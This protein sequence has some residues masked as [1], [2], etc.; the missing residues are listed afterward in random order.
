MDVVVNSG[1]VCSQNELFGDEYLERLNE[2]LLN[3][4]L[5]VSTSIVNSRIVS[6]LPYNE[7]LVCNALYRNMVADE[8][9]LTATDLCGMTSMLKSQMN[10]TLNRLEEK[11]LIFRQRSTVDRRQVF[12]LFN[13]EKS[14]LY[15]SQHTRILKFLDTVIE[16]LGEDNAVNMAENLTRAADIADSVLKNK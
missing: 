10:R 8:E 7:A 11:G 13:A 15:E 9:P 14:Y 4:W 5:R 16:Q 3:A 2:K 6:E 12:V 1:Y